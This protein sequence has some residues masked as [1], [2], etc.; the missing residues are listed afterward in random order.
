MWVSENNTHVCS[1][2]GAAAKTLR[3]AK[4]AA[5]AVWIQWRRLRAGR[6]MGMM[7]GYFKKE[8][9]GSGHF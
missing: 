3:G 8:P 1:Q 4:A 5:K 9:I 6:V 2:E 7:S